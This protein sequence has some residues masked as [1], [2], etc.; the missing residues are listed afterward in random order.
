MLLFP[1]LFLTA[2][3]SGCGIDQSND[4]GNGGFHAERAAAAEIRNPC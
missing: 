2:E 1:S 3:M 4:L